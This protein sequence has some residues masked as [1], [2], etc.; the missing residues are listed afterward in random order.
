MKIASCFS[1]TY[2]ERFFW[3]SD[4]KRLENFINV[5]GTRSYFLDGT[6]LIAVQDPSQAGSYIRT[7]HSLFRISDQEFEIILLWNA[8]IKDSEECLFRIVIRTLISSQHKFILY[9]KNRLQTLGDLDDAQIANDIMSQMGDFVSVQVQEYT[10]D[11]LVNRAM[12]PVD[13]WKNELAQQVLNS[14]GLEICN[15]D[16]ICSSPS[17]EEKKEL[18]NLI[19]S[20][21]I[22]LQKALANARFEQKMAEIEENREQNRNAIKAQRSLAEQERKAHFD[23]QQILAD[24]QR[25]QLIQKAEIERMSL[26]AERLD[27]EIKL[28]EIRNRPERERQALEEEKARHQKEFTAF[29]DAMTAS[30]DKLETAVDLL[31]KLVNEKTFAPAEI[32]LNMIYDCVDL[33]DSALSFLGRLETKEF[34]SRFFKKHEKHKGAKIN[35]KLVKALPRDI[36]CGQNNMKVQ[37]LQM[38]DV[39]D[40]FFRSPLSG[41]TTLI[42][43]GT[44]GKFWLQIPNAYVDINRSRIE[45]SEI[46]DIPGPLLPR[47]AL[48]LNGLYYAESENGPAGWEE[49]ILLVT[50]KPLTRFLEPLLDESKE[51]APFVQIGTRQMVNLMKELEQLPKD[52][53]AVGV[54]GF[55]VVS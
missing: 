37:T 35:M 30:I 55:S 28:T 10:Y 7:G 23:K 54:L 4:K 20:Q 46:T 48:D 27:L 32:S 29:S 45:K 8:A 43:L 53:W 22:T 2:K 9:W 38:G 52:D 15:I 33:S 42:N 5:P 21:Q 26:E 41:Y 39:L 18:E 25:A 1:E 50:Q 49:L 40:I 47:A 3:N 51:N 12:L 31:T 19:Q 6:S 36:T 11:D 17:L 24:S 44:S 13:W 14:M 16:V 34:F